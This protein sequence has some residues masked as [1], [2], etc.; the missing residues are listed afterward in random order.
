MT[1][2][3]AETV[4]QT[5]PEPTP[6]SEANREVRAAMAASETP[7]PAKKT[8]AKKAPA[9]AAAKATPAKKAAAK[10][11]PPKAPVVYTPPKNAMIEA[12]L[13]VITAFAAQVA[14]AETTADT[15][16]L[17]VGESIAKLYNDPDTAWARE[18]LQV[19]PAKPNAAGKVEA[20]SRRRFAEWLAWRADKVGK[21]VPAA[22]YTWRVLT[23]FETARRVD[24]GNAVK[25][26]T[27]RQVRGLNWL[28]ANGFADDVDAV[29]KQAVELAA[30]DKRK[31]PNAGDVDQAVA[32]FKAK[33]PKDA[34]TKVSVGQRMDGK[35][36]K[37]KAAVNN[38]FTDKGEGIED[39]LAQFDAWYKEYRKTEH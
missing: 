38:L 21:T 14:K 9:K 32:N 12:E 5:L 37:A 18:Y 35:L 22:N 3:T 19:K 7:A 29:W 15:N 17:A 33:Q 11:A 10:T 24:P 2:E 30:V 39:R 4:P 23:A 26:T 20:K 13:K 1:T 34:R 8:A 27:E 28:T 16:T 31:A 6:M 25:P 36:S